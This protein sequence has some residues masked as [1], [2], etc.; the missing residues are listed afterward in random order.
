MM[1]QPQSFLKAMALGRK[2]KPKGPAALET[3]AFRH[4][5]QALKPVFGQDGRGVGDNKADSE[6]CGRTGGAVGTD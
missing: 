3:N 1:F 5:Q 2:T 6:G 4:L